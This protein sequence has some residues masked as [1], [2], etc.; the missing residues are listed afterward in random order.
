MV[1]R[2]PVGAHG[3]C[4]LFHVIPAKAGIQFISSGC[5]VK[6]GMTTG[7][8]TLGTIV[9]IPAKAGIQKGPKGRKDLAGGVNP[10]YANPTTRQAP[11]GRQNPP[12]LFFLASAFLS[13]HYSEGTLQ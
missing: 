5:R 10:R 2:W 12:A 7:Y 13:R 6:P 1:S 9:V 3:V 4:P 8:A 11:K